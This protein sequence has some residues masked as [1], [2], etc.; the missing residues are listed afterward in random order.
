MAGLWEQGWDFPYALPPVGD[1]RFHAPIASEAWECVRDA[2]FTE[3]KICP[4]ININLTIDGLVNGGL[5]PASDED[6]LYLNVYVP[7]VEGKGSN[8]LSIMY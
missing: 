7:D 1:L 5:D 4:Q 6:C 3:D 8:H 2:S